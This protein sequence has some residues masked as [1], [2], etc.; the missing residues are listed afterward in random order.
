[1]AVTLLAF[2]PR[3]KGGHEALDTLLQR[4]GPADRPAPG[5]AAA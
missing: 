4:E 1:M 3:P 5:P 2:L